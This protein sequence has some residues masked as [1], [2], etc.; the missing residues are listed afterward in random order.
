MIIS[1]WLSSGKDKGAMTSL[2]L[3][4]NN[5]EAEGAKIVAGAIKVTKCT[6]A[7]I[8]EPFSCPSLTSQSTAVVCYYPQDM[9]AMTSLNLASNRICREGNMDGIKAISSAVKV[10]AVILV[11]F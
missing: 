3:A 2:N 9:R 10:L 6:P 5:L 8:L 1:A 7:I 11:P 4:S